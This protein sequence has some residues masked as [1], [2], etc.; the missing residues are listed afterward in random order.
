[1][2]VGKVPGSGRVDILVTGGNDNRVHAAKLLNSAPGRLGSPAPQPAHQR[3]PRCAS[4]FTPTP[5]AW[6]VKHHRYRH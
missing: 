3:Q 2:L 4:S 6:L 1:M 5:R